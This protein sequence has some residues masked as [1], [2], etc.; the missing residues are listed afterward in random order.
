MDADKPRCKNC[1]DET[2]FPAN[3]TGP[4]EKLG[5][6]V[7]CYRQA[8]KMATH[9]EGARSGVWEPPPADAYRKDVP[10]VVKRTTFD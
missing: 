3:S 5:W 7:P 9:S 8:E 1:G 2:R 6:C 4:R 10:G